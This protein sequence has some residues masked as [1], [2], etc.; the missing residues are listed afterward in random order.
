[1]VSEKSSGNI[2]NMAAD[3]FFH[4]A[5]K[6]PN[7]IKDRRKSPDSPV[8]AAARSKNAA[9]SPSPRRMTFHGKC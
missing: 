3:Y 8:T 6:H 9:A 7:G 1:M 5:V 4:K 2:G